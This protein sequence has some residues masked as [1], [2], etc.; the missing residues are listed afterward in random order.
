MV[1][2]VLSK[3][4][5]VMTKIESSGR[6]TTTLTSLQVRQ[7]TERI[8]RELRH[9]RINTVFRSNPRKGASQDGL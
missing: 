4:A 1:G 2:F 7:W 6:A 5:D 3:Q 8:E 9:H